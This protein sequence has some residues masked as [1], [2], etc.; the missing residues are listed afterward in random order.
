LN[1]SSDTAEFQELNPAE[2]VMSCAGIAE[3]A[4]RK[5]GATK[6]A[7]TVLEEDVLGIKIQATGKIAAR[8]Y[9]AQ[10]LIIATHSKRTVAGIK[11]LLGTKSGVSVGNKGRR[12][13]AAL[14]SFSDVLNRIKWP[15]VK[16]E[17][18]F[19][20]QPLHIAADGKVSFEILEHAEFF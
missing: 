17:R 6:I 8:Y 4:L 9:A 5:L 12:K 10:I 14:H 3:V 19:L 1:D 2:N 15:A 13:S 18:Q 16:A 20:A 7:R 11:I